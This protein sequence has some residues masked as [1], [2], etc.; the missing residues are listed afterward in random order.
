ENLGME[1]LGLSTA[2]GF[3]P[4]DEH[5]QTAAAGVYAIGDVIGKVQLAHAASAQGL[6][7]AANA[8][9]G[10]QKYLDAAMP[11]CIYTSPEIAWVGRSEAEA[12]QEGHAVSIGQFPVSGNG[13]ALTM[14]ETAGFVKIVTDEKTGEILGAQIFGPRATELVAELGLAMNLESTIA[15][16]A[17]TI[18]PHPTISEMLMEAAHA[19]EG[20]CVHKKP[21]K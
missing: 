21:E 1:N 2:K 7:A 8:A 12:R 19:A 10:N 18:H 6:V 4:V 9:G 13:R 11:A 5:L 3:I 14:G 20:N 17:A 15:E 16:V